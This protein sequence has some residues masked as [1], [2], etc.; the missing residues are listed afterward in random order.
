MGSY[1]CSHFPFFEDILTSNSLTRFLSHVD[2][3]DKWKLM[4]RMSLSQDQLRPP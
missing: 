3:V 1:V 2:K 4:H